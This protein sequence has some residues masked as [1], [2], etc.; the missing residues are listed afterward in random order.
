MHTHKDYLSLSAL[1]EN[2]PATV[3]MNDECLDSLVKD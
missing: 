1:F 3:W 2:V